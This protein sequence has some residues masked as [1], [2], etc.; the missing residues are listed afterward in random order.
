MALRS[1]FS[2]PSL[3]CANSK[4]GNHPVRSGTRT[5]AAP[6]GS[7]DISR[8]VGCCLKPDRSALSCESCC[9]CCWCATM[10]PRPRTARSSR[11][12]PL[13]HTWSRHST[14][15]C[16]T[17]PRCRP[18]FF[19]RHCTASSMSG[20]SAIQS[21]GICR[22]YNRKR[23]AFIPRGR[24]RSAASKTVSRAFAFALTANWWPWIGRH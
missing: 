24:T 2:M 18:T 21:A 7:D 19:A 4:C 13:S 11:Y 14:G 8:Y 23:E 16:E 12:P 5:P 6:P 22:E 20:M 17:P 10:A 9:C 1:M 15:R 3:A